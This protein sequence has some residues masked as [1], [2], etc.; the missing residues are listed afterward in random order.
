MF[1]TL[2]RTYI[3]SFYW[4]GNNIKSFSMG[5]TTGP[6]VTTDK[7]NYSTDAITALSSANL[8]AARAQQTS[9]GGRYWGYAIGGVDITDTSQ[10]SAAKITYSNDVN[11][12]NASAALPAARSSIKGAS[13]YTALYSYGGNS[14][15]NSNDQTAAYKTVLSNDTTSTV[16]SADLTTGRSN[17]GT[18]SSDS[19]SVFLG[20]FR[21]TFTTFVSQ[22]LADKMPFATETTANNTSLA[23]PVARGWNSYGSINGPITSRGYL[24]GTSGTHNILTWMKINYSTDT[25]TN[26]SAAYD[27]VVSQASGHSSQTAGYSLGG[28]SGTQIS[29]AYKLTFSNDTLNTNVDYKTIAKGQCCG[30]G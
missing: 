20:G 13:Y 21:N 6:V 8:P 12:S 27:V 4:Y 2:K 17:G 23:L 3:Q 22:T 25:C 7:L 28:Y 14:A 30:V 19:F 29:N 15:T 24:T 10:T 18:A 11:S 26:L 5:G 9:G 16:S 1:I